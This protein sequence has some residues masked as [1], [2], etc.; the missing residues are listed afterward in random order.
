M[1]LNRRIAAIAIGRGVDGVFVSALA[2][3]IAVLLF[4]ALQEYTLVHILGPVLFGSLVAVYKWASLAFSEGK[5]NTPTKRRRGQQP[6][7]SFKAQVGNLDQNMDE[8][9]RGSRERKEREKIE[10]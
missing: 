8:R 10:A 5:K 4:P 2:I 9:G 1:E 3:L 7:G 6:R